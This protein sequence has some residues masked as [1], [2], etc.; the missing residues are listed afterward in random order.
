MVADQ[1]D[2]NL[3]QFCIIKKCKEK[4]AQVLAEEH[5]CFARIDGLDKETR[6]NEA[7]EQELQLKIER[8]DAI[9]LDKTAQIDEC[10]KV[11]IEMKAD[12][13]MQ[14]EEIEQIKHV[15]QSHMDGQK[16][17]MEQLDFYME[18]QLKFSKIENFF[19]RIEQDEACIRRELDGITKH[20]E[21]MT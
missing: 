16:A 14:E 1:R 5:A 17:M 9:T 13:K 6:F 3:D 12:L 4:E 7:K 19:V 20:A 11:L 2:A 10:Q 18:E 15:N 21:T 8:L